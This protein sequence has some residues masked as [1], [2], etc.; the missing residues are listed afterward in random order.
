MSAFRRCCRHP[1]AS[2][3]GLPPAVLVPSP[4]QDDDYDTDAVPIL[5]PTETLVGSLSHGPDG[6][7]PSSDT[8][9]YRDSIQ[10]SRLKLV[11]EKG[12]NPPHTAPDSSK[13]ERVSSLTIPRR[14][15]H[16]RSQPAPATTAE[17]ALDQY[18]NLSPSRI[19]LRKRLEAV[20]IIDDPKSP[21]LPILGPAR[22]ASIPESALP[23]HWRLDYNKSSSSFRKPGLREFSA[24]EHEKE[25]ATERKQQ[26]ISSR[27]RNEFHDGQSNNANTNTTGRL[28]NERLT[29]DQAS[30]ST[31][32]M[33]FKFSV[34]RRVTASGELVMLASHHSDSTA[35][36]IHLY[37]MKISERVASSNSN[38]LPTGEWHSW[39]QRTSTTESNPLHPKG[40]LRYQH[41]RESSSLQSPKPS[42]SFYP[43]SEEELASSRR[44][45][46]LLIESLPERLR[47]LKVSATSGDL[48][49]TSAQHS[50]ITVI[51]RSRFPTTFT[52][53]PNKRGSISEELHEDALDLDGGDLDKDGPPSPLLRRSSTEPRLNRFKRDAPASFDGSGEWHL[54]PP[55]RQPTGLL[56]RQPTGLVAR[57]P[58]GT[59]SP[60]D[61]KSV[62]ER[63]LR[64][65]AAEDNV[66]ARARAGSISYE[67]GRDDFKRRLG[68]RRFTRTSSPLGGITEDPWS[69]QRG[70]ETEP[71][72]GRVSPTQAVPDKKSPVRHSSPI[73]KVHR[74]TDAISPSGSVRS[75][76]SW[77]RYPSHTF[78]ERNGAA[79]ERDNII[80]RDFAGS[81]TSQPKMSKK[82]SRSMTYGKKVRH[83]ITTFY[84]TRR[85]DLRRYNAGH[86]SSIAFGGRLEYPELE[87]PPRTFDRVLLSE[88]ESEEVPQREDEPQAAPERVVALSLTSSPEPYYLEGSRSE[89][90]SPSPA[91]SPV[92]WARTYNKLVVRPRNTSTDEEVAPDEMVAPKAEDVERDKAEQAEV[93]ALR[94]AA[95]KA[96][97][98]C[99]RRSMDTERYPMR[100]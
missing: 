82:K 14:R 67:I 91:M 85:S 52:D 49:I 34:K 3:P 54:S 96:A 39:R 60:D 53:E 58:T 72:S 62:W 89:T 29:S 17:A 99:L 93:D 7:R 13:F 10:K 71:G 98:D 1:R 36:S 16:A 5:T 2:S 18:V 25:T 83:K 46:M 44:S 38:I 12:E 94:E 59:L 15:S 41:D 45:S 42:S 90:A 84:T 26:T 78:V 55:S 48:Y 22:V 66:I 6:R 43:S 75:V 64:E 56:V 77:T 76:D 73:Q 80:A 30:T 11:S 50:Q 9:V 47:R 100:A 33:D 68:S 88:P 95:L 24:N 57:R 74:R 32:V 20:Q 28:E 86:R 35:A 4:T 87:I 40:M 23:P 81:P 69:Q 51:P 27:S 97:D 92:D 61:G 63:A 79:T 65:H 70:R 21:P 8:V 31:N 19:A 37:D